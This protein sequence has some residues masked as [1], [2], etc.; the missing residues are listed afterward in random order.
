[1]ACFENRWTTKELWA[2]VQSASVVLQSEALPWAPATPSGPCSS[3]DGIWVELVRL[4]LNNWV[5]WRIV[6]RVDGKGGL[7]NESPI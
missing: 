4:P 6:P 7:P 2:D 5:L 1:M 3:K